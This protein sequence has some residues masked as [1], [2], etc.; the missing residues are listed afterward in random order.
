MLDI[1]LINYKFYQKMFE[2]IFSLF[3]FSIYSFDSHKII[4]Y[5]HL[6][7]YIKVFTIDLKKTRF[8]R[9]FQNV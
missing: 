1:E 8:L 7:S 2:K 3:E 4:L 5:L 6:T 9:F